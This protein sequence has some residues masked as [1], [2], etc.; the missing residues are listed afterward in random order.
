MVDTNSKIAALIRRW[1]LC[2]SNQATYGVYEMRDL[3]RDILLV[4]ERAIPPPRE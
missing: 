4:V 2:N 1:Q 3:V